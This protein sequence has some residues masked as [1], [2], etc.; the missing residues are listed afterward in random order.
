MA[1][2]HVKFANLPVT[3]QDRAVKFYTERVGLRL[4]AD[5]A[6]AP[7]WRW[8]ELAIPGA[9]TAI[10][11]V[12]R[13]GTAAD[14]EPCLILIADDVAAEVAR[15]EN[16]GVEIVSGAKE[17]PWRKGETYALIRDSENNLVMLGQAAG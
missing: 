13:G 9:V 14:D 10:V 2:R 1:F 15:L 3:D 8:I 5:E 7:G 17:A 12:R 6:M 4:A 11:M 16:S